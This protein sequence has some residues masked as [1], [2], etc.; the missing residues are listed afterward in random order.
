M[1]PTAMPKPKSWAQA[2]ANSNAKRQKFQKIPRHY[3]E[4]REHY[5]EWSSV[6]KWKM[7]KYKYP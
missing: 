3:L 6:F 4:E 7:A 5:L 2:T 1:G